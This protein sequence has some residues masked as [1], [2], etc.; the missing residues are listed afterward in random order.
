MIELPSPTTLRWV[1][2]RKAQVVN[3]VRSGVIT[4]KEACARYKLSEEELKTWGDLIDHHGVRGLRATRLQ[5]YR[6]IEE[7]GL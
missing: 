3:A 2:R 6:P 5:E 1:I 4:V 7:R